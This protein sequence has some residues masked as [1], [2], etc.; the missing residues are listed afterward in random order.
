MNRLLNHKIMVVLAL[1]QGVAG[2]VR[3]FNWVEIGVD[4]FRQ[5]ILLLPFVGALAVMHGLVIW[6]VALL[7]L[8]FVIGAALRLSWTRWA[9]VVAAIINLLLVIG[10]VVQGAPPL[11]AIAWSVVPIVLLF[12]LFSNGDRAP[13]QR[14][15][16]GTV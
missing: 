6:M 13:G 14:A 5:G 10:G 8:L 3:G 4:L 9:G 2:L 12:Y 15:N 16:Q 11:Q 1:V 7:Y